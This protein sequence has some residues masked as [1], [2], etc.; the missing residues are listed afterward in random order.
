MPDEEDRPAEAAR[1]ED[2]GR[3]DDQPGSRSLPILIT[4]GLI[5]LLA[6]LPDLGPVIAPSD[7]SIE[8]YHGRIEAIEPAPAG[9]AFQPPTARVVL[10]DGPRAGETVE[11]LLE[12]PG[13]AQIASGYRPGDEVVVTI[14]A[15]AGGEPYVAVSDRWRLPLL[16]VLGLLFAAAVVLVGGWQG[17]RALVAL[18]LT[19][20]VV[21]KILIPLV[22][23]GAPPVPLAVATAT[24]VTVATI[25]LTEGPS[26]VS[27]AAILG[28]AAALSL[29]GL[30]SLIT[31][32]LAGFTNAAG[33]DLA[34]LQ[35]AGGAGVDLRGLLLASFIL[36]AVG[37]LDDVT[38]TQAAVVDGLAARGAAGGDLVGE[39]MKV[40]RSHIAATVNT[41]FLA[42]LGA[43]LPL[44][45][46]LSVTQQPAALVLNSEEVAVEVV[47]TIVG[48]L[49]IIAAVPLTTLFAVALISPSPTTLGRPGSRFSAPAALVAGVLAVA[50]VLLI[51]T[52]VIPLGGGPAA[53]PAPTVDI[54]AP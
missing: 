49:G 31:T 22:V 19:I 1:V 40:G 37:V 4:V 12:G 38:V 15:D 47:R 6:L 8:A 2:G 41:L 3:R 24:F 48:S 34:F 13:G 14:T 46:V 44:L 26:R 53:S 11:A 17:A 25:L 9:E 45:V 52:A 21:L 27:G 54:P 36:G 28:V 16:G 50:A 18:G 42:Y 32:A 5:C 39:S 23:G 51:A 35:T 43:G 7:E 29:T 20:A 30:L 10:L 33:S